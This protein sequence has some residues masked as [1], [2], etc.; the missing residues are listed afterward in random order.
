LVRDREGVAD[1]PPY[2]G[3]LIRCEWA[4]T[5]DALG[6]VGGDAVLVS[7]YRQRVVDR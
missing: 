1:G 7:E 4:P 2:E 3:D 6:P 5:L